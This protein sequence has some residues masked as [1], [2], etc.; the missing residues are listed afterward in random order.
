MIRT[1]TAVDRLDIAEVISSL[2]W[3]LDTADIDGFVDAFSSDGELIWDAFEQS[4]RWRGRASLRHF[5]EGLR[6]LPDSAGRQHVVANLRMQPTDEGARVRAYVLVTLRQAD[7]LVRLNVAGHYEDDLR[8]EDGRW[9]VR[10]RVIRDWSG[11][12]LA[13]FAG[14]GGEQP[15]RE[16]PPP[17]RALAQSAEPWQRGDSIR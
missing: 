3:A 7:G 1:L 10:R 16:L 5:I 6:D 9:R 4:L 14:Q 13:N 11:P 2:A 12:V 8:V 15:R 17:L